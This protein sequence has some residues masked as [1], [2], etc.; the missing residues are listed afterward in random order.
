MF[1]DP[2]TDILDTYARCHHCESYLGANM[3]PGAKRRTLRPRPSKSQEPSSPA[4]W[5][6]RC[7]AA[8]STYPQPVQHRRTGRPAHIVQARNCGCVTTAF[9]EFFSANPE[10]RD[11][12]L[13][14]VLRCA[15]IRHTSADNA[16]DAVHE[17]WTPSRTIDMR[18]RA[19][20]GPSAARALVVCVQHV[21]DSSFSFRPYGVLF[22]SR[23][24]CFQIRGI[25]TD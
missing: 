7:S 24:G 20:Y 9:A 10:D 11:S 22:S 1:S 8:H 13:L 5:F 15:F 17:L 4:A 18:I 2:S 23:P 19:E 12:M 14:A 3:A 16:L 25:N 21:I 6:C